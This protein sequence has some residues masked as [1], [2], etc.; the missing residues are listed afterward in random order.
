M[1]S[2]RLTLHYENN[3]EYPYNPTTNLDTTFSDCNERNKYTFLSSLS[4]F[5][6]RIQSSE[7]IW[8]GSNM[9]NS[10]STL[11][12]F[13][14]NEMEDDDLP[15]LME[16][17]PFTPSKSRIVLPS[18]SVLERNAFGLF[19]SLG[20]NVFA[21]EH[22]MIVHQESSDACS[23]YFVTPFNRRI[24][25][26]L[27]GDNDMDQ[28]EVIYSRIHV[29]FFLLR[30]ES[31]LSVYHRLQVPAD[32]YG[33]P[34]VLTYILVWCLHHHSNYLDLD[35][36]KISIRK[37]VL[38]RN[39]IDA[40]DHS[41]GYFNVDS[42][43][44]RSYP[45]FESLNPGKDDPAKLN[46][47]GWTIV[48]VDGDGNCGYYSL[49]LGLE[50]L[51]DRSYSATVSPLSRETSMER[52]TEWQFHI[53]KLRQDLQLK[54]FQLVRIIFKG[55]LR[56]FSWSEIVDATTL[57]D[58]NQLSEEFYRS[59]VS[60]KLYFDWS[61]TKKKR[62][63]DLQMSA[64]WAP[65]VFSHLFCVRVIVYM[66]FHRWNPNS[67]VA[68]TDWFTTTIFW[69]EKL[70]DQVKMRDGLNKISDKD[71]RSIKTIELFYTTGNT[72]DG[73]IVDNHF[74]WLRRVL[75]DNV[76]SSQ[77]TDE[78][79]TSTLRSQ[80]VRSTG[81]EP[82]SASPS[83]QSVHA[84]DDSTGQEPISNPPSEQ[85][86]DD[87]DDSTGQ[88][89]ISDSPSEQNVDAVDDVH[90]IG[91]MEP[92]INRRGQDTPENVD[93]TDD[94]DSNAV[95][96]EQDTDSTDQNNLEDT[97]THHGAVS[98]SVSSQRDIG[99]SQQATKVAISRGKKAVRDKVTKRRKRSQGGT[100]KRQI[101][102][103]REVQ[104][105]LKG[106]TEHFDEL[107]R[108]DQGRKPAKLLYKSSTKSFYMKPNVLRNESPVIVSDIAEYDV[109]LVN[110]AREVPNKWV[111][112]SLGDAGLLN[113]APVHLVTKV[114]TIHQ[115]H[116]NPYCVS[117]SMA[118]ALFYCGF[119]VAGEGLVLLAKEIAGMVFDDGIN[120]IRKFMEDIVPLIGR[121]T[122]YGR[123][124]HTH[125]RK[126]RRITWDELFLHLTPFPT[127]VIPVL[128]TGQATH[129]FVVVDDLIFD[130]TTPYALK[131]CADSV[132]WLFGEKETEIYQVLRFN[133]KVSPPNN[134]IN[135]KYKRPITY[136]WD[137]RGQ[138]TKPQS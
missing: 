111:G 43:N 97:V 134:P 113:D 124:P 85:N 26:F 122:L 121:P 65:L 31:P 117:Y 73:M 44:T 30:P 108:N 112:P 23:I 11:T 20:D 132:K 80:L 13:C 99:D 83:E 128:P 67:K 36:D 48:D 46:K 110:A 9:P 92:D 120:R 88:E 25:L 125:S 126:M 74:R 19:T 55:K 104:R 27:V 41:F 51:G 106:F 78:A 102:Q 138:Q 7:I 38:L 107:I 96:K 49:V 16:H 79:A 21:Y 39:M 29:V 103:S 114:A 35:L 4:R 136:H 137:H 89:P 2:E 127:I 61:I 84:V 15:I 77:P 72:T 33:D 59:T 58:I 18:S 56:L 123:R 34:L 63:S 50:N 8:R 17:F 109:E 131:L 10:L 24:E 68:S 60:Q 45:F 70:E 91:H 133:T 90:T 82:I 129:A 116:S 40:H 94:V 22:I 14:E 3:L 42:L 118:S 54:S 95:D 105:K 75:C 135:E 87:V 101:T 32:F 52:H 6:H 130:S 53:M 81:Q 100:A 86:V 28:V 98:L 69:K 12:R 66:R 119:D 115:Q 93:D 71:F 57:E 62:L 47:S 64:Y 1:E 5:G 76:S 37:L